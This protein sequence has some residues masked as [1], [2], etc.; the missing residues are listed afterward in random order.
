MVDGAVTVKRFIRD[1]KGKLTW[2][3]GKKACL[4]LEDGTIYEG[5][6]FGA[7]GTS[8]GELVF[9]TSL[10]GYQE[11][12]TD[13]SYAGQI[14]T[15][16]YPE[17]GNYGINEEDME[18]KKIYA[19]GLVIRHL[20]SVESNFRSQGSLDQFLKKHGIVGITEIDT[21]AV[22]RK[23]RDKGAMRCLISTELDAGK[24]KDELL[25]RVKGLSEMTG[26]NLTGE[27]ST[28]A[29]YKVGKGKF[30]VAVM[31]FGCKE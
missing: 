29:S 2:Q 13:P 12:L 3:T 1:E 25:K 18:S 31:D 6:A 21:R 10:M 19:R 16:T 17:V 20:S 11:I 4:V 14:I 8:L 22:T 23:I 30:K 5:E 26:Q 9:N 27:V 15:L 7:T 28:K 24:D